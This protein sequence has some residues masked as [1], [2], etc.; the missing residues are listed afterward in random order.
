MNCDETGLPVEGKLNWLQ[1]ASTAALTYYGVHPKRGPSG[2]RAIGILNELKGR[3][4]HDAYGSYFQFE[5]CTHALCNAH[6]VRE[7]RFITEQYEQAWADEMAQLLVEA[8]QEVETSPAE[9]LSLNPERLRQYHQR[10]DR[11]VQAG[12]QADSS[13]KP[14]AKKQPGRQKQSPAKNLLD[15]LLKYKPDILAFLSDFRVP[16]DNNLA[17]RDIRMM[18]VKQKISGTFR[19]RRGADTFC[20][21]R[22]YISTVRKQGQRVIQALYKALLGQPFVPA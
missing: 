15:R 19:T 4:I 18:K 2:M 21:L 5:N 7:L 12:F 6:H 8:T 20:D 3:A 1:V 17:E 22:S 16:F 14:A 9:Q 13:T 11:L 10:Y